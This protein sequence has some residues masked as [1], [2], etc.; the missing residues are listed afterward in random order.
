MKKTFLL[1]FIVLLGW[2]FAHAQTRVTGTITA[3]DNGE[4]LPSVTVAVKG[5]TV[6]TTTSN[7]GAYMINVPASG[8]TLIFS[9][10]GLKTQEIVINKRAIIDVVMENDAALLAETVV[11]GYQ[12][13]S[14]ERATG[15]FSIVKSETIERSLSS[16]LSTALYGTTAGMVGKEN[17]DGTMDYTIRGIGT[18]HADADPLIVINGFPAANGFK[19]VNPNDV[20]SVTVLKDAAAASIWGARS[21]NGVIVI[22]TK[23][24]VSQQLKVD[25]SS[26]VRVGTKYDLGT[27]LNMSSSK[28]TVDYEQYYFDNDLIMTVYNNTWSQLGASLSLATELLYAHRNGNISMAERSAG[29]DKL[30]NINNKEQIKDLLLQN[31]VLLQ[32]N[33][34]IS[35]ASQRGKH[36]MSVMQESQIGNM[37]NNSTNRWR[38]NYNNQV[39]IFKWLEFNFSTTVHYVNENTSGPSLSEIRSISPYEMILNPD[40][41]Y[42]TQLAKN[43]EQLATIPAGRLPYEDWSYNLLREVNARD[44]T[45]RDL[46]TR[47]I[48]GLTFKLLDGLSF[49]SSFMFEYNTRKGSYLYHEDSYYVRDRVNTNLDYTQATHTVNAQFIP[50]GA[51]LRPSDRM[52][53]NYMWRNQFYFDRKFKKHDIT[54]L[55]GMEISEYLMNSRVYPWTYGFNPVTN[56]SAPLPFGAYTFTNSGADRRVQLRNITGGNVASLSGATYSFGYRND[57]YVSAYGNFGYSFDG[58]YVL[59]GSIRSDA[60]N[61]ITDDPAYRWAPL[62]SIGG[63]WHAHKE[64]FVKE[65]TSLWLNRLVTRFTF[66]YN[67]NVDKTTSPYALLSVTATPSLT[68]G[69]FTNAV[70]QMG[71]PRLRWERTQTLNF[72]VDFAILKNTLFGSIDLYDKQGK[73]IIGTITVASVTG[74]TS[75]KLNQANLYNRGF[76][77]ELGVNGKIT[78][79]IR[80]TTKMN[81]AYNKNEITSLFM[82]AVLAYQ[83]VEGGRRGVGYVE[84]Y[85]VNSMWAYT[86]LGMRDG[87]P[88]VEGPEG[89]W[90]SFN[91]VETHNRGLGLQFMEYLGPIRDPHT[92]GWFGT[93]STYGVNL[94][95]LIT[96][97]FGGHFRN[98]TWNYTM[99]GTGKNILPLVAEEVLINGSDKLPDLPPPGNTSTY[100]WDRYTPY[101]ATMVES[102]S[103]IKLKE[104]TLDYD[105]PKRWMDVIGLG[106]V[107]L[108]AQVRDLGCLWVA[109]SRRYDPE[110]L[111]GTLKPVTTFAFGLNINFK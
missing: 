35:S 74:Q 96:G 15:S 83:L 58:K 28:A 105:L 12:T 55:A 32:N 27:V 90:Q 10:L 84:G 31:P 7:D 62:W 60:S 37:I 19:D 59:T 56:T 47:T 82:P 40:G 89:S 63:T 45:R 46:N 14:R 91:N 26:N 79:D 75:Q 1:T 30:R 66:G 107:R 43:R 17:S 78:S 18:L 13:I 8:T 80:F 97:A 93:V 49:T 39:D 54:V 34:T 25:V 38:V 106:N 51:I 20:E 88:H 64:S 67:G 69:T 108:Y 110:W 53:E 109:N 36:Y 61:L 73:D 22:V 76:E 111:P 23:K 42:A 5:T 95:F 103:F 98:P 68:T 87:L 57:R 21:G 70:A 102:S 11:T 86:Y 3:A 77:I 81:Y 9:C 85:P 16:N 29:L 24:G 72:G 104:I 50:K 100:L 101:L 71:N 41:S 65:A 4:A 33:V 52:D 99:L 6:F 44:S 48:A 92:L 94:S 2:S